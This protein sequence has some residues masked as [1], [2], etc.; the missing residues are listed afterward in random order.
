[1]TLKVKIPEDYQPEEFKSLKTKEDRDTQFWV[2]SQNGKAKVYKQ[3]SAIETFEFVKSLDDRN[4]IQDSSQLELMPT[5]ALALDLG[6]QAAMLRTRN[7]FGGPEFWESM[8][9]WQR[10]NRIFR[11]KEDK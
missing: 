3:A 1:M 9:E 6:L 5:K 11:K 7:L 4:P 2:Y 10:A 8:P